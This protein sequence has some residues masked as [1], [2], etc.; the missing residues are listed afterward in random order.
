MPQQDFGVHVPTK[1]QQK[2]PRLEELHVSAVAIY[3]LREGHQND[4]Q[5]LFEV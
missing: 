5:D 1:N 2:L 4:V 3:L